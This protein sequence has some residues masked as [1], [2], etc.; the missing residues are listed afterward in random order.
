MRKIVRLYINWLTSLS[1]KRSR[2]GLY[3]FLNAEF[4]NIP[5]N[6]KV[7]TVGSG[8]EVNDV[9]KKH[10]KLHGFEFVSFDYDVSRK[11]DLLGDICEY[12]FKSQVFD[13]V[14]MCEVLEHLPSPQS[15]INTVY[16]VLKPGGK[17]ILSTPFILPIHDQPHDY[18]RFTR[19][20]LLLLLKCFNKVIVDERNSYFEAIDVLWLRLLQTN[21]SSAKYLSLI[22]IPVVYFFQR[23]ISLLLSQLVSTNVMTTGYVVTAIK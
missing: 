16:N 22:I 3:E 21:L 4:A 1:K 15:G 10:A 7:L 2:Q 20:G 14:V 23:P 11:P 13:A 18:F 9:L 12:D 6:A 17:L 19:Y 5:S 8:G